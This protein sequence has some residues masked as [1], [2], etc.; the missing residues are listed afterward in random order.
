MN[1][2]TITQAISSLKHLEDI[3]DIGEYMLI[4]GIDIGSFLE[5]IE[6]RE[7]CGQLLPKLMKVTRKMSRDR[8]KGSSVGQNQVSNSP[9]LVTSV[10]SPHSS[11]ENSS[12]LPTTNIIDT[13]SDN[14]PVPAPYSGESPVALNQNLVINL[15]K[16][17]TTNELINSIVASTN[18]KEVKQLVDELAL[19]IKCH[20]RTQLFLCQ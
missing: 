8:S 9:V 5:I 12:S 20:T 13:S 3:D 6:K 16:T 4:K 11:L 1:Q 2:E 14:A 7:D 19:M 10:I 18:E 17:T 15:A